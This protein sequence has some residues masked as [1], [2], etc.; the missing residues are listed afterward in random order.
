MDRF[1]LSAKV[2]AL[3]FAILLISA[4]FLNKRDHK[5]YRHVS[6]DGKYEIVGNYQLNERYAK[7]INCY[8]F[9]YN[10]KGTLIKIMYLKGGKISSDP[11]WGIAKIKFTYKNDVAV[12]TATTRTATTRIEYRKYYNEQGKPTNDNIN[13]VHCMS[14]KFDPLNSVLSVFCYDKNL[15]IVKDQ[16]GVANYV[17]RIRKS[18]DIFYLNYCD[19]DGK[20]IQSK[21]NT[22]QVQYGK[23]TDTNTVE[24]YSTNR[25]GDLTYRRDSMVKVKKKF[26]RFDNLIEEK[27]LNNKGQLVVSQFSDVALIR[28]KYD[29]NGNLIEETYYGTDQKLKE[30]GILGVAKIKWK[31]D[32]RGN[33]SEERYY[34]SSN[35]LKEKQ[36]NTLFSYAIK[37]SAY[38]IEGKLIRVQ[39]L[40]SKRRTV[41]KINY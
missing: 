15:E 11:Y 20:V 38:N 8:R 24:Q 18:G 28:W 39:Y 37:R 9:T 10:K 26:D 41:R 4:G 3:F 12:A 19:E 33:M 25:F 2:G 31:Y 27:Y 29:R 1:I 40:N 21:C 5:F 36:N 6:V 17:F 22:Y 32:V 35:K 7:R 23:D 16:F 34:G 30:D 13:G 14:L